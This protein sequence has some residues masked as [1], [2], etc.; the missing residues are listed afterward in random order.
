LHRL[1]DGRWICTSDDTTAPELPESSNGYHVVARCLNCG[2]LLTLQTNFRGES[3]LVHI[4]SR[5]AHC[6]IWFY[7]RADRSVPELGL[8]HPA[9]AATDGD[10]FLALVAEHER[11]A[12]ATRQWWVKG[13]DGA[14]VDGPFR[15][16]DAAMAAVDAIAADM[17]V[18]RVACRYYAEATTDSVPRPSLE[19]VREFLAR[20]LRMTG[21]IGEGDEIAQAVF[22]FIDGDPRTLE[23]WARPLRNEAAK[24]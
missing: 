6:G 8:F 18:S 13:P 24:K 16:G 19:Q 3:V 4:G 14:T 12:R 20:L 15:T 21:W 1:V 10:T 22:D 23:S 5:H 7:A 11:V 17:G 9:N 2:S